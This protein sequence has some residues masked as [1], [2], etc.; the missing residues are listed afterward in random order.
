MITLALDTM[1]G[2][3]APAIVVFGAKI[4]LDRLPNVKFLFYGDKAKLIPLIKKAK[5]DMARIE[6]HH[7]EEYIPSDMKPSLALRKGR[8]SSMSLAINA[9]HDEKA[10][11]MVSAGNTGALV[12]LSLFSLRTL[13]GVD[14]PAIATIIPGVNKDTLMLDLGANSEST[15]RNLVESAFMANIYAKIIMDVPNPSIGLLNIGEEDLK[16]SARIKETHRIL[17]GSDNLN[18]Y[19]FV[20]GDAI[21][22]GEVDVIVTDGF[23]GNVALKTIE[24]TAKSIM[25]QLSME[26]KSSLINR[27]LAGFAKLVA[28]PILLKFKKRIDPRR[29]NGAL[30]LGLNG[31]CIKS[32]GGTDEYGFYRAIKYA[33]LAAENNLLS[34]IQD[35][36]ALQHSDFFINDEE[37]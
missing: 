29:Y 31:V 2:D 22:F 10:Q 12:A 25:T 21:R 5:L 28:A 9:V 35:S 37:S 4:A 7:T 1:G 16:G 30:L 32:H 19:G 13:P 26:A 34:K 33:Y 15:S 11:A 17:S 23:T 8:A 14:R 27:I 24:G 6:I 20:E 3:N 36:L 18:Y